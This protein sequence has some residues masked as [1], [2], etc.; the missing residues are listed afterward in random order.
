MFR[1]REI[2]KNVR[3]KFLKQKVH[4]L[5]LFDDKNQ[6]RKRSYLIKYEFYQAVVPS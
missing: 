4:F 2:I 1:S 5:S 6:K 3:K